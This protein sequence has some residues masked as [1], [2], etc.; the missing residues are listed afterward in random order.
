MAQRKLRFQAIPLLKVSCIFVG[1]I[2]GAGICY[3]YFAGPISIRNRS[4]VLFWD[5]S[6]TSEG[7]NL[8]TSFDSPNGCE[9][10]DMNGG[11]VNRFPGLYC[12]FLKDGDMVSAIWEGTQGYLRRLNKQK[13]KYKLP[14]DVDH[15][16]AE[17]SIDGKIWAIA[18]EYEIRD[19]VFLQNNMIYG[20]TE[21]GKRFFRWNSNDHLQEFKKIPGIA[22]NLFGPNPYYLNSYSYFHFNSIQVLPRNKLSEKSQAFREGNILISDARNTLIFILDPIKGQIVWNYSPGKFRALHNARF[23]PNQNILFFYNN[24][25]FERPII[26][27]SQFSLVREI[28]PLTGHT[29]WEYKPDFDH[30]IFSRYYGSA[31]RL[32]NGNTLISYASGEGRAIEVTPSGRVVW[33]WLNP[34]KDLKTGKALEIFRIERLSRDIVDPWLKEN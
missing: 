15:D 23:L 16:I 6:A 12:H 19:G 28:E 11:I 26:D 32:P 9:L 20:F 17:S 27:S 5:K 10:I 30:K 7:Y 31:Q 29:V 18:N 1:I 34:E 25:N 22:L 4:G 8:I 2:I 21:K 3:L 24:F 14:L 13:I 33:K